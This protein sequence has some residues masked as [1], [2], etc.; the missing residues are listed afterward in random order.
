MVVNIFLYGGIKH[1]TVH[2]AYS[3]KKKKNQIIIC[4]IVP[5]HTLHN[6]FQV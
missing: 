2:S 3:L 6:A 4:R 5:L 1:P